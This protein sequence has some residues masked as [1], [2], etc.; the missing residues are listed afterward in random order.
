MTSI[1]TGDA[2]GSPAA[3]PVAKTQKNGGP[4]AFLHR[5]HV[6]AGILV[7]PLIVIATITGVAYALAPSM[8]KAVYREQ[9]TATSNLPAQPLEKQVE[10]AQ[11][12]H[13]D[14]PVS[15][16]QVPEKPGQTTR[17]MF[18]DEQ[19]KSDS[20][21]HAVFVD[22]GDLSVKGDLVQYGSSAALPLRAWIS[23]GH[24]RLW[25]DSNFG[26]LYSETAA[27]WMG[28]LALGGLWLWWDR[29]RRKRTQ[30]TSK[31]AHHMRR[32]ANVGVGISL[33]LLFLTVTGLTWSWVAGTDIGKLRE[34]M[35]WYAPKPAVTASAPASYDWSEADNVMAVAR[36]EG[37][38]GKVELTPPEAGTTWVAK[39][40]REEWRM[41]IETVAVDGPTA[42]VVDRI[43]FA[44]W[45][46]P[47]KL[48]EWLINAHMGILFG[49]VNQ[50]VLA[51]IG[52]G[53]LAMIVR[54]YAMWFGRGRG[55]S[56]GKLPTPTRWRDMDPKVA[57]TV[58]VLLIAYSVVAPLF[59]VTL[60]AFVVVDWAWRKVRKG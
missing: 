14:L 16:V 58:V 32:H 55:S 43:H 46:L 27:S 2:A 23:E 56:F 49:W 36:G 22:P 40:A 35:D 52:V 20:Y 54:G 60:V 34:A 3:N 21:R 38:A 8:E 47:A 33:G 42:G 29:S 15:A 28:A 57:A 26:R 13:P 51:L 24:R 44:D 53:L 11:R 17:V 10:V 37:L 9:L 4:R 48:T 45:P 39:E 31:R 59:G 41:G 19:L 6:V 7:A 18:N 25:I 5:I 50:L 12:L 30:G 1:A